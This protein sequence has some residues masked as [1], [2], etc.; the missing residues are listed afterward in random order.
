MMFFIFFTNYVKYP[1]FSKMIASG[2]KFGFVLIERW[3]SNLKVLH[4]FKD[5]IIESLILLSGIF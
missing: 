1:L 5:W 3:L 2:E 4:F